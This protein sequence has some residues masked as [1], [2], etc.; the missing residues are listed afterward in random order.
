M[1]ACIIT[2]N[3]RKSTRVEWRK[4]KI[5]TIGDKK[6]II[7]P[8]SRISFCYVG[9]S[10][11]T[12]NIHPSNDAID[13]PYDPAS[14]IG[15]FWVMGSSGEIFCE[16]APA[17]FMLNESSVCCCEL[18]LLT[19]NP[20][21]LAFPGRP[22]TWYSAISD[23]D[24]TYNWFLSECSKSLNHGDEQGGDKTLCLTGIGLMIDGKQVR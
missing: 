5:D 23:D 15:D 4:H 24:I 18:C 11:T 21:L 3:K 7:G 19:I 1:G 13:L 8:L 9:D 10:D 12:R 16:S 6:K 22:G 20:R 2:S 14:D 17:S